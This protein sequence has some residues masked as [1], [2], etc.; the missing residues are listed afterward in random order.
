MLTIAPLR[1][2]GAKATVLQLD[3]DSAFS[4]DLLRTT[5]LAEDEDSLP[6]IAGLFSL[7]PPS[8]PHKH[9]L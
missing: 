3:T 9:G 2:L 8:G 4:R 7:S 6:F 1:V 5:L